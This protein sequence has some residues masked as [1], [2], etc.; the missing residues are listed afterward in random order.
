V[1]S[2]NY[3]VTKILLVVSVTKSGIGNVKFKVEDIY[4]GTT[5]KDT[6][7]LIEGIRV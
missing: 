2:S 1:S 4:T 5:D 6:N 3:P 7:Q